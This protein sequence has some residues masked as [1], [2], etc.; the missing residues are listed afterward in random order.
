MLLIHTNI[1]VYKKYISFIHWNELKNKLSSRYGT[2]LRYKLMQF[3]VSSKE[4][5]HKDA[6]NLNFVSG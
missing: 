5:T 2:I 4:H 6:S 1:L 3:R